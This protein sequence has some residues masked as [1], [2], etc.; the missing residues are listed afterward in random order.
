MSDPLPPQTT[1]PPPTS[2]E[3]VA[4]GGFFQ[5]L[6]D[7]YFAPREAFTRI[8]RAPGFWLPLAGFVLLTLG[9]VFVWLSKM[10][11][12]EFAKTTLQESAFWDRIPPEQRAQVIEQTADRMKYVWINGLV[13]GL[14]GVL[15][16]TAVL[17]LVYR[18]FYASEVT[19]RQSL[20]ITAW[21]F[22]AVSLVTT[23]V[24]LA[25][26]A[27]KGDWNVNPQEVVQA[28]PS[29]LLE[30]SETAKTLWA[31]LTSIDVFSIWMVLLLAVGF[32]VASRRKTSAALWGVGA[33]W[34][35]IIIGKV[36][37]AAIF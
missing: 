18:F 25:V 15:V 22:F 13:G 30:K 4:P 21:T 32:A 16:V 17:W 11:P 27:L 5:N 36:A 14:I 1:P 20:A 26:M 6:I 29:L 2:P 23:P 7:V 31:F 33:C 35:L 3:P 24:T 12:M 9:F 19:F 8:V 10:D 28:N 34:V 37:W